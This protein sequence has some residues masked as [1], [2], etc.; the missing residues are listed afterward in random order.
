M[1]KKK[2]NAVEKVQIAEKDSKQKT[3]KKEKNAPTKSVKKDNNAKKGAVKNN[4]QE[5]REKR[6]LKREEALS[7]KAERE[8]IKAEKRV[9]LAKIKSAKKAEREKQKAS[10][11]RERNR[12]KALLKEKKAE[13]RA[14]KEERKHNLKARKL[15]N[16]N[17]RK[18]EK[19]K[20]KQKNK[21][22]KRGYGGWLAAVI[23]LAIT[24][25]ALL[26]ALTYTVISSPSVNGELESIYRKSFLST[27]EQVENID[28]NLSKALQTKDEGA[29]GGY[30]ADVMINSEIAEN[31]FSNLPISEQ[32][33]EYASKII[34]QVGD[35]S[36]YLNKKILRGEEISEE[37]ID[38][39]AILYAHNKTLK[40]Y[41]TR[42]QSNMGEGYKFSD[43]KEIDETDA[44]LSGLNE[45]N[46]LSSSYP[47]LIYDGPFSDGV[48]RVE[49]KGLKGQEL[50][51]SE[52]KDVFVNTFGFLGLSDVKEMGELN[53]TIPCYNFSG[54]VTGEELYAQISKVGGE[55]VTFSYAGSCKEVNYQN[56]EVIEKGAEF[57]KGLGYE[58]MKDVWINLNNNVYTINYVYEDNGVLVYPDMVKVRVCAETGNVI[59]LEASSYFTNHTERTIEEAKV[60]SKSAKAN[61][62]DGLEVSAVRKVI[63][64]YGNS[65]EKLCYEFCGEIG[66]D[67]Y[68]VYIDALTGKQIEMFKVINSEQG[69][70]LI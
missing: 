18:T 31:E 59:G 6:A 66:E 58:N 54:L 28:L 36:K 22:R 56:G 2:N 45:L 12:R 52:A 61:I 40:E 20:S 1:E 34:N 21:Q 4:K 48:D 13:K 55:I 14:Q 23:S 47:E 25:L 38:N 30:L 53:S 60:N 35:F 33:R 42:A 62:S 41:L 49:V 63:V 8:K 29:L 50:S 67:V 65:S 37:D 19:S 68:F 32:N 70:L 10:E 46:N 15:E 7:K 44:L 3:A 26:S 39:L 43:L 57:L 9:E 5:R 11:N 16:K 64:P 69:Q 24:S 17:A 27:I 51:F